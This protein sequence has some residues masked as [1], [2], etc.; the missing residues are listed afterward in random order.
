[1]NATAGAVALSLSYYTVPELSPPAMVHAAARAGFAFVGLRLL[2]GQPGRDLA[3]LMQDASIERET[4]AAMR[5]TGVHAL[6]ASGARLVP[7]TDVD[8]FTPFL[9][10]AARMGARHVL[11]TVDD[12][13]RAR[14]VDRVARLCDA[15]GTRG[16]TVD[17]EFVPWMTLH[18]LSSAASLV[19]EVARNNL[20]IAVDA[21]HFDR[22]RSDIGML[23]RLPRA[24]FRYVQLCDAPRAFSGDRDSLL[25]A[26]VHDRRFPGDGAIDLVGL[27]RALPAGIPVALEIPMTALAAAVPAPERLA[28]AVRAT[29]RVLTQA[30][31]A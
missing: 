19:N 22:S 31:G 8:A 7:T 3:P 9:D 20:G 26:A 16:L 5:A 25:H 17:L 29:R 4:L 1:V 15:A 11:A 6:D 10:T 28:R 14:V 23:S 30:Y 12:P 21:L 13:D 27:L 18:D 2:N 24:W